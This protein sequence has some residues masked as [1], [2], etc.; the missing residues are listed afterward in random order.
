MSG[1]AVEKSRPDLVRMP[2][3]SSMFSRENSLPACERQIKGTVKRDGSGQ[4]N[5]LF[6]FIMRKI[7][8]IFLGSF[9][10]SSLM[11]TCRISLISDGSISLDTTLKNK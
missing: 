10:R 6:K 5:N 3:W 8:E 4:N 11:K 7:T 2:R 1:R 9:D